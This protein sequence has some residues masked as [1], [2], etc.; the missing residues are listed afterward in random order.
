MPKRR[1]NLKCVLRYVQGGYQIARKRINGE[2]SISYDSRR[3]RYRAK[4]TIGW[5]IDE[6]YNFF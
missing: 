5:K 6:K 2:G 4:I 3:K 1:I